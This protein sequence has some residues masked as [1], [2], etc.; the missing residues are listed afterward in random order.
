MGRERRGIRKGERQS[1][2][3]S[4]REE[5]QAAPGGGDPDVEADAPGRTLDKSVNP[6]GPQVP[7][8]SIGEEGRGSNIPRGSRIPAHC[9]AWIG[10]YLWAILS[11]PKQKSVWLGNLKIRNSPWSC[12]T[13]PEITRT[14]KRLEFLKKKKN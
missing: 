5:T 9:G 7:C 4:L 13:Y 3:G 2:D 10:V 6:S 12:S 8:P 11:P 1:Q 14:N